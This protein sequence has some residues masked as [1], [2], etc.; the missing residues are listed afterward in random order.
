M[1]RIIEKVK[2]KIFFNQWNILYQPTDQLQIPT[3]IS[4]FQ[5]IIPPK[6]R[7]W[8]DPFSIEKN[9]KHY[10][11]VEEFIY[12]RKKGVIAVIE[13]PEKSS[14]VSSK[15][16]L[17]KDYHLSYPFLFEDQGTLF[18]I[19]ETSRNK[20]IELYRCTDFPFSWELEEVMIDKI[21][22]VDSTLLKY[23][24]KYWLFTTEKRYDNDQDLSLLSIYHSNQLLGGHWT[25]HIHNPVVTNIEAARPAG[26]IIEVGGKLLRPSQNCSKHYGYG[27]T[28][29]QIKT[30]TEH[31]FEE[32][33]YQS[34]LPEA[35]KNAISTHTLNVEKNLTVSDALIKRLKW[36]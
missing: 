3:S 21:N 34:L 11:F 19:P 26:K 22:A 27:I 12:Q 10:L 23:N 30:L 35:Y 33:K 2:N 29:N 18:M 14:H 17:E 24:D 1:Q 9:G 16:V 13:L 6:D 15:V 4:E 31:Q 7:F 32:V 36:F 28:L 8:A 25:P 20:T 5:R